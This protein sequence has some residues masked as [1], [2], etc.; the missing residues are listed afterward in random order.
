MRRF[1]LFLLLFTLVANPS[2]AQ[3]GTEAQA[4]GSISGTVVNAVTQQPVAGAQVMLRA[5]GAGFEGG[6]SPGSTR[7]DSDG[8][9]SF[10]GLAPGRYVLLSSQAG[11]VSGNR[12]GP[13]SRV[14]ASLGMGQQLDGIVLSL[15]PGGVITGRTLNEA[16]RP[17]QN[18]TVQVM[19]VSYERGS[20]DLQ[21]AA[22]TTTNK[23]GEYRIGGLVPGKYYLHASY[24]PELQ[25][26]SASNKSYVPLCY[27]SSSDPSACVELTIQGGD[28]M[29]GMDFEF[30]PVATVRLQGRTVDAR[31][32]APAS[33]CEVTI[34]RDQGGGALMHLSETTSDGKGNF[35]FESLAPGNYTLVAQRT[36]NSAQE[37]TISGVKTVEIH[38]TN[39]DNFQLEIAP[40]VEVSGRVRVEGKSNIDLSTIIGVLQPTRDSVVAALLPDVDNA[41]IKADGS[42]TFQDVPQGNYW[43][44]LSPLPSGFYL[45]GSDEANALDGVAVTRGSAPPIVELV[46]SPGA[47]QVEGTV[48]SDENPCP[49][50]AVI[51]VPEENGRVRASDYKKSFTD[52][53]GRFLLR[54]LPPGDYQIFAW[55]EIENTPYTDPSFLQEYQDRGKSVHLEDGDRSKVELELIPTGGI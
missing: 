7:T 49:G 24:T 53:S 23:S 40:G 50:A 55:E 2:Q 1:S 54:G 21:E 45:K 28:E 26:K 22:E 4:K 39:V 48:L 12:R 43:I 46:L 51:L 19:K 6:Q 37:K 52:R 25:S 14:V 41:S 13:H 15:L 10:T 5:R 32:S 3:D 42:F 11:Y 29:A 18:V 17:L 31:K 38:D 27:P 30:A 44:S 9:F 34:L 36:K 8:H 33:K 20:R 16:H 35:E 47:A